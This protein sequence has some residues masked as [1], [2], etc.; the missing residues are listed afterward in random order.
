MG[1]R[2]GVDRPLSIG[3][4]KRNKGTDVANILCA[5]ELG[6]GLGHLGQLKPFVDSATARGHRVS[7]ALRQLHNLP[8]V[9]PDFHG[10]LFQAPIALPATDR[11]PLLSFSQLLLQRFR[12]E[13]DMAVLCRC[14]DSI[15]AATEPDLV[16][17]NF[18]PGALVASLHRPWHK[19]IAGTGYEIPRSDLPYFGLFPGTRLTPDNRA[20]LE[21][22]ER[23]LLS[24]VNAVLDARGRAPLD[25]LAPIFDQGKHLLLTLPETDHIGTRRG[26]DYLGIPRSTGGMAPNWP[27]VGCPRVFAYLTPLD[28][29]ETLL[30]ELERR[31]SLCVYGPGL[32]AQLSERFPRARFCDQ[33]LDM[34][35]VLAEA[36][37][38]V[39]MGGHITTVQCLLAGVPMLHFPRYQEQY[40]SALRTVQAGRGIVAVPGATDIPE[41]V[42]EALALAAQ[43]RRPPD[44]NY[45][46]DM[47]GARLNARLDEL[48]DSL[49][50]AA[51][52]R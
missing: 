9:M 7:L 52:N 37:L 47:G 24:R 18:A 26:G 43:G 39:T 20:A 21:R 35:R 6:G 29:I 16:I 28:G 51:P 19:W 5:W 45:A 12:S 4:S 38:A 8:L 36:D 3:Y 25:T 30:S 44:A 40:F 15:F 50:G 32:P 49:P 48:F 27:D 17:Y 14:W 13:R 11:G 1:Q 10:P 31:C 22:A 34:D 46:R 2:C 42:N 23:T 41:K 33:P